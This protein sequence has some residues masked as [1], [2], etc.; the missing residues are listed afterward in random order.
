MFEISTPK[1]SLQSIK[2][3]DIRPIFDYTVASEKLNSHIHLIEKTLQK[4]LPNEVLSKDRTQIMQWMQNSLPFLKWTEC[5]HTPDCLTIYLL[6]YPLK[7]IKTQNFFVDLLKRWLIPEKEIDILSQWSMS[8][9]HADD[10]DTVF[11]VAEVNILV[12]S[13]QDLA[14]MQKNLPLIAKEL[15]SGIQS[16]KYA[17]YILET[18]NLLYDRKVSLT[19]QDLIRLVQKWPES[20]DFSVFSEIN[21]FLALTSEA[22]REQRPYRHITRLACS[23]YLL[24]KNL[25]RWLTSFPEKRHLYIRFLP[26]TLSFTFGDKPVLGLVVG[27][28]LFDQHEFFNEKH[29]VSGVQKFIPKAQA[30]KNTF[31]SYQESKDNIRTIYFEIE[32][33]DGSKFTINEIALLKKNLTDELKGHIERLI[34]A[35]FVTRNE[36]EIMK[37]ILILSQELKY[38]SDLPQVSITFDYQ[39]VENLTFSVVLVR[40]WKA[41]A[42]PVEKVLKNYQEDLNITLERTQTIGFLRKKYPKEANVFRLKLKKNESFIRKDSSVNLILA[43]KKV[44]SILNGAFGEVRDFNGG[45]LLKQGEAFSK[46][47]KLVSNIPSMHK[48][49]LETF[50][51]SINPIELQTRLDTRLLKTFSSLFLDQLNKDFKKR[52]NYLFDL[53]ENKKN[54]MVMIRAYD[55]IIR[56]EILQALGEEKFSTISTQVNHQGLYSLGF[57]FETADENKRKRYLKTFKQAINSALNKIKSYQK[58]RQHCLLFPISLDPRLGGDENSKLFIKYLFEGLMTKDENEQLKLG[59]AKSY[60]ISKDKKTYT[61]NLRDAYWSNGEKVC[62]YDFEYAWKKTLDPNFTTSFTFVFYSIKNARE[63]KKGLVPLSKVGVKAIDDLTLEV[64]LAYPAKYFLELISLPL[65]SPINHK[66][67]KN[68]PNWANHEGSSFVCNGPYTLDNVNHNSYSLKKNPKYWNSSSIITKEIQ[69]LKANHSEALNMFLNK[70]LDTLNTSKQLIKDVSSIKNSDI[71]TQQNQTKPLEFL[72]YNTNSFL[73]H[74]KNIRKAL[75]YSI[76]RS[77]LS[78]NKSLASE[79]IFRIFENEKEKSLFK[80]DLKKAQ[81]YFAKG[82][83]ELNLEK[84]H[85][86]ILTLIY[87]QSPERKKVAEI[88]KKKWKEA[89]GIECRIEGYEWKTMFRKLTTSEYHFALVNW[90]SAIEDPIYTLNWFRYKDDLLNFSNWES[91]DF[92]KTLSLA[93]HQVNSQKRKSLLYEAENILLEELP[94]IPLFAEVGQLSLKRKK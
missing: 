31:Y 28:N 25:R 83:E 77:L 82:L 3:L 17:K 62:A 56:E 51:Y 32:K 91:K 5:K 55:P 85:I 50:F 53:K 29:I 47:K 94:A 30:V 18:K 11:F 14:T 72:F 16:W 19:N 7:E 49:L 65:F 66:V 22:F 33:S 43:R 15:I 41:K 35:V 89:L 87:S 46:L 52:D 57:I 1:K 34:P 27:L 38:V 23:L 92:Q 78:S 88:L 61:F 93:D 59:I 70:E 64:E 68:H 54:L 2:S 74:N 73:F 75:S 60:Q 37:S 9:Q 10:V 20:M 6:S 8:F 67:D 48:D 63:A 36:E 13:G 45:M 24:R 81:Y 86:P 79:A 42:E 71:I 90:V 80:E 39:S 69:M 84:N 44:L 40:I 4:I 12:E 58:V 76:D 26:T 21:R